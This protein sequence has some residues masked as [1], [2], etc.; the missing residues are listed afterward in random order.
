MKTYLNRN[1]SSTYYRTEIIP[2]NPSQYVFGREYWHGFSIYIPTD[3]QSDPLY[4]IVL[5][6][7]ARPDLSL[8]E[9]YRN[10]IFALD[11][12]D[13]VW[14]VWSRWDSKKVTPNNNS[15]DGTKI[16]DLGSWSGDNARPVRSMSEFSRTVSSNGGIYSGLESKH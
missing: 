14:N 2:K 5:Q 3:Y 15:Y 8:G 12:D 11:I 16:W 4:E 9:D 7:H 13:G 6:F 1:T 10:P